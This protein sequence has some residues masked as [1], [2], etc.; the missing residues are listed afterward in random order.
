MTNQLE[1]RAKDMNKK[2]MERYSTS[3]VLMYI[4]EIQTKTQLACHLKKSSKLAKINKFDNTFTVKGE[5]K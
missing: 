1:K 2:F 5:K 4:K 3:H